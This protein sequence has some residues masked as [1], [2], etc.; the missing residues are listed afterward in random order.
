MTGDVLK[1]RAV[2]HNQL[3]HLLDCIVFASVAKPGHQAAPAMSSGGDL[4]GNI[5]ILLWNKCAYG[6]ILLGDKFFVCWDPD[7]VPTLRAESYDYPP[8]KEHV[9]KDVTRADLADHFASYNK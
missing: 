4:D 9:S 3:F 1:L 5:N 6:A 7:L 2:H 8:N